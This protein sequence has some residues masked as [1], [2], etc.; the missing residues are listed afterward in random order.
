MYSFNIPKRIDPNTLTQNLG[1]GSK[2]GSTPAAIC[3]IYMYI[4]IVTT[5]T[6]CKQN[7][8]SGLVLQTVH[9]YN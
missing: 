6:I 7:S 5:K 3:K 1:I 2:I 4:Y 8:Q 9:Q